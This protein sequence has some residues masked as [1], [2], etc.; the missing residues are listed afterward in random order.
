MI[1]P[2]F[3]K[4]CRTISVYSFY[5]ASLYE[6]FR[7]LIKGYDE[8]NQSDEYFQYKK[9]SRL[10][11][12]LE[13]I[14]VEYTVLIRDK[15]T[16]KLKKMEYDIMYLIGRRNLIVKTLKLYY[17]CKL[18]EVLDILNDLEVPFKIDLPIGKQIDNAIRETK[19]LKNQINIKELSFK[20]LSG[21]LDEKKAATPEDLMVSLDKTALMLESHLEL[22]YRID[23]KTTPMERW[24]NLQNMSMDRSETSKRK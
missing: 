19:L 24:V 9:D 21:S 22:G 8:D 20:K 10:K 1:A 14:L 4:S 3:H 11:K 18:I 6:D 12:A 7:H 13:K 17:D 2:E 5:K 23:I 15:K 16:L